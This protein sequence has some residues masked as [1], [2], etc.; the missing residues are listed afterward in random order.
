MLLPTL[1]ASATLINNRLSKKISSHAL[2]RDSLI[3]FCF[4]DELYL[5]LNVYTLLISE[6]TSCAQIHFDVKIM[7]QITL[8][9]KISCI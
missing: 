7:K 4:F 9:K 6:T 2:D 8:F 3:L 1:P 5:S